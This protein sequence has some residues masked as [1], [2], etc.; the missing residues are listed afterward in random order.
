MSQR[1]QSINRSISKACRN[2]TNYQELD[3]VVQKGTI[4]ALGP[5]ADHQWSFLRF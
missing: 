1:H 4:M 5:V 2:W 3:E